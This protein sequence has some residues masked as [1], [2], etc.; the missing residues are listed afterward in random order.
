MKEGVT[1]DELSR[2]KNAIRVAWYTR[3]ESNSGIRESLS[4]AESAGTYR[5]L[6]DAPKKVEAV[7]REDVAARREAVPREGEP[8]RPPHDAQG[9]RGGDARRR[10]G[11]PPPGMAPGAP[12]AGMPG[13][14]PAMPPAAAA[15]PEVKG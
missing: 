11:G 8:Q 9:R 14:A 1:D 13:T 4:Q 5:D 6:L 15:A 12:P 7:T 10:P 3:L 2:A